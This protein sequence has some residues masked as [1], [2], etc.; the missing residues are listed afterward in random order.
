MKNLF[1]RSEVS[2]KNELL[3]IE[4]KAYEETIETFKKAIDVRNKLIEDCN[5]QLRKMGVDLKQSDDE[6]INLRRILKTNRTV[7]PF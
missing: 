7:K 5:A 3:Q 1:K 4:I 2:K 6:N